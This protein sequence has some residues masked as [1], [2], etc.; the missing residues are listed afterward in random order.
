M[1]IPPAS[2]SILDVM[3]AGPM[4]AS[5][6]KNLLMPNMPHLY[7]KIFNPFNAKEQKNLD[8][9]YCYKYKLSKVVRSVKRWEIVHRKV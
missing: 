7:H 2:L 9:I 4:R 6:K 5:S 1:A 3:I 8:K